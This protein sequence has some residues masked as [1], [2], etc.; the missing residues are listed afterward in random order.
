M[1]PHNLLDFIGQNKITES[2]AVLTSAARKRQEAL[3]HLIFFGFPGLGKTTLAEIVANE[4]GVGMQ[5]I[6]GQVVEKAT[7]FAATLTN[8]RAGDILLIQQIESLRRSLIELL[9]PAMEEYAIDIVI[10]KGSAA[11]SVR[12]KLPHFTVIGITS[13]LFQVDKRLINLMLVGRLA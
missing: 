13:N 7:D 9:I 1:G 5:V 3:D 2:L 8:L 4:M 12:L 11:R 10:G 6:T